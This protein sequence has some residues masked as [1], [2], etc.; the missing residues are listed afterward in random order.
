MADAGYEVSGGETEEEVEEPLAQLLVHV[1]P[2]YYTSAV[3]SGYLKGELLRLLFGPAGVRDGSAKV[4]FR[5]EAIS[6]KE[7][8]STFAVWILRP[9]D[10]AAEAVLTKDCGSTKA[11]KVRTVVL[12]NRKLPESQT[13]PRNFEMELTVLEGECST[14]QCTTAAARL[15]SGRQ[16]TLG[17]FEG[18]AILGELTIPDLRGLRIDKGDPRRCAEAVMVRGAQG[19]ESEV[20]S[21]LG[22]QA[23]SYGYTFTLDKLEDESS[24]FS[25]HRMLRKPLPGTAAEHAFEGGMIRFTM[26]PTQEE[27]GRPKSG[28]A[29]VVLRKQVPWPKAGTVC[30]EGS[31][32]KCDYTVTDLTSLRVRTRGV[33]A[34]SACD[35][36][37][38]E[39]TVLSEEGIDIFSQLPGLSKPPR[40]T[41]RNRVSA[42]S[43]TAARAAVSGGVARFCPLGSAPCSVQQIR[44]VKRICR[45]RAERDAD[46]QPKETRRVSFTRQVSEVLGPLQD[47]KPPA[48]G[49]LKTACVA[50]KGCEGTRW[51]CDQAC[52]QGAGLQQDR[53]GAAAASWKGQVSI[54][55]TKISASS[56]RPGGSA[57]SAGRA[58]G[59][60]RA[61]GGSGRGQGRG[62]GSVGVASEEGAEASTEEW[63]TAS[64]RRRAADRGGREVREPD[65]PLGDLRHGKGSLGEAQLSARVKALRHEGY[66]HMTVEE[67]DEVGARLQAGLASGGQ[68]ATLA[69]D[70]VETLMRAVMPELSALRAE[71]GRSRQW[72]DLQHVVCA[73]SRPKFAD[74]AKSRKRGAGDAGRSGSDSEAAEP[75]PPGTEGLNANSRTYIWNTVWDS[76]QAD[77]GK[78][79]WDKSKG[80]LKSDVSK[81]CETLAEATHYSKEAMLAVMSAGVDEM[82]RLGMLQNSADTVIL[83]LLCYGDGRG[84]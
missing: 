20:V 33:V 82:A 63:Q 51:P 16:A 69:H 27:E 6:R 45:S 28:W 44:L 31:R 17:A 13:E 56:E 46:G 47:G 76:M 15:P 58:G 23:A 35:E 4:E 74:E 41:D 77:Y 2:A 22:E 53:L 24:P 14:E 30:R 70:S 37:G 49:L 8:A 18:S 5:S 25:G 65:K 78:N 38:T 50:G 73:I 29:P 68:F 57:R 12:E 11:P 66:C 7:T 34:T 9:L 80:Y 48:T 10:V 84:S 54:M 39:V 21:G 71:K 1:R 26:K 83:D 62:K 19:D 43:S 42:E 60:G 64:S 81:A 52:V 72:A 75:A 59:F 32:L 55:P 79:S 36:K 3:N 61:G 40:R 67:A